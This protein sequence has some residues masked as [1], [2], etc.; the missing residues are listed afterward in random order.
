MSPGLQRGDTLLDGLV[1]EV[2]RIGVV[3]HENASGFAG[4]EL[5]HAT[6]QWVPFK[7]TTELKD[8]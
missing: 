1:L 7:F 8:R 3:G 6:T 5:E 2:F 4:F